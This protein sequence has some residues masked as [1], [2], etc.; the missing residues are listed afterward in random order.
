MFGRGPRRPVPVDAAL[1]QLLAPQAEVPDVGGRQALDE[2]FLHPPR[3]RHQHVHL[4]RGRDGRQDLGDPLG[5]PRDEAGDLRGPYGNLSDTSGTGLS[6][7]DTPESKLGML[8][9]QR[10]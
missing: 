8:G 2:V 9:T 5:H 4:P 7:Q 6:P 1:A 3:R 10:S